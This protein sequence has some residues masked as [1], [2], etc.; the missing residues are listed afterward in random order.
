[1]RH[2]FLLLPLLLVSVGCLGDREQ[3][4]S[5]NNVVVFIDV[6]VVPMDYDRVLGNQSVI[7][8]GDRIDNVG[9]VADVEIPPGA[10]IVAGD[11]GYLMPGLADMHVHAFKENLLTYVA[12]GVTTVRFMDGHPNILAWRDQIAEG[13]LTTQSGSSA[14]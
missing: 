13:L 2:C 1:M 6:N 5:A 12:N 11:G 14:S 3:E 10:L 7:V 9:P 4:A 8:I